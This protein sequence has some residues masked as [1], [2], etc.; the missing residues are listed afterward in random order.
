MI[1]APP[2]II[3]ACHRPVVRKR[4][5]LQWTFRDAVGLTNDVQLEDRLAR[6]GTV[7]R[8]IK[9]LLG[10]YKI[11][12]LGFT[13][14]NE[15]GFF[16]PYVSTS[17]LGER[18][19]EDY[20]EGVVTLKQGIWGDE[21][22]W[23]YMPVYKGPAIAISGGGETVE[24]K[25]VDGVSR[26]LGKTLEE[27]IVLNPDDTPSIQIQDLLKDHGG[28]AASDLHP[29]SFTF[30]DDVQGDLEWRTYGRLAK[31]ESIFRLASDL[32]RS[33][34]GVL[35]PDEDGVIRY[36]TEFPN[37]SG[38]RSRG[39]EKF[40]DVFRGRQTTSKANST[41]FAWHRA[42]ASTAAEVVTKYQGTWVSAVNFDRRG[43]LGFLAQQ[44][45]E[46]QY[47]STMRCAETLAR[48]GYETL[49]G[50]VDVLKWT[51]HA[52]GLLV[53]LNDR[54][55]VEPSPAAG[56]LLCR[57]MSKQWDRRAV[58]L[59]AVRDNSLSA[60]GE[61]NLAQWSVTNFQDSTR[62]VL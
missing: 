23:Y 15:D 43:L 28:L 30:A 56:P 42:S 34:A 35:L 47:L 2:D 60:I 39:F 61:G 51:T 41:S 21:T 58:T 50:Y 40:P 53:Q 6:I 62:P 57:V 8:S 24:F 3:A 52:L 45:I 44:N 49:A 55:M 36:D 31:G 19:P 25:C 59:E 26:T 5:S 4:L 32:A 22:G 14:R 46:A 54:V 20:I 38:S 7:T 48:M 18:D 16:D 10:G 13:V 9:P 17:I 33:G 37:R 1:S 11:S 29:G 12:G 27:D